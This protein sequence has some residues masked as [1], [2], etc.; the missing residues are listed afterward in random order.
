[1]AS[2]VCID[3]ES[4]ASEFGASEAELMHGMGSGTQG[5]RE[6]DCFEV[7]AIKRDDPEDEREINMKRHGLTDMGIK[8]HVMG[9]EIGMELEVGD[10]RKSTKQAI[11]PQ[12]RFDA[13]G[14]LEAVSDG[15]E[16]ATS[17]GDGAPVLGVR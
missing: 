17:D 4:Q 10:A 12:C 1:M 16:G 6:K 14:F 2:I 9:V 15:Q 11:K 8:A 7:G 13:E 3:D 5:G